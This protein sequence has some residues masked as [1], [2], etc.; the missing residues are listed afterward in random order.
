[1]IKATDECLNCDAVASPEGDQIDDNAAAPE[2]AERVKPT[3]LAL[4]HLTLDYRLQSRQLR[5]S[6]GDGLH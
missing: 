6:V 5:P 1:M 3:R 4:D 2:L